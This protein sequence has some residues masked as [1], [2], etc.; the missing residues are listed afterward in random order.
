[1]IVPDF[2]FKGESSLIAMAL[3]ARYR[4]Y[5]PPPPPPPSTPVLT[6]YDGTTSDHNMNI[7]PEPNFMTRDGVTPMEVRFNTWSDG[8][9]LEVSWTMTPVWIGDGSTDYLRAYAGVSTNGGDSWQVLN[10]SGATWAWTPG[11]QPNVA[12]LVGSGAVAISGAASVRVRLAFYYQIGLLFI[13]SIADSTN[14]NAGLGAY[15]KASRIPA[16]NV[17]QAPIGE[18]Q[19]F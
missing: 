10:Y 5:N 4:A 17:V 3:A 13:K 7:A 11:Q 8:D 2:R 14:G 18:L 1:M 15:L 9:V 16:A 6:G 12:S 19:P